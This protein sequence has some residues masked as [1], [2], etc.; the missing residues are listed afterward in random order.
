MSVTGEKPVDQ[1]TLGEVEAEIAKLL[2]S[3][4]QN[5]E[6]L[7]DLIARRSELMRKKK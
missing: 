6:R 2:S 4:G 5:N 7:D 3:G 1:M